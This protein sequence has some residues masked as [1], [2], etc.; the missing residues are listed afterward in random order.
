MVSAIEHHLQFLT[1]QDEKY[2]EG[3]VDEPKI[4]DENQYLAQLEAGARKINIHATC[5]VLIFMKRIWDE[6]C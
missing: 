2:E 5:I 6:T 1:A 4:S 3:K